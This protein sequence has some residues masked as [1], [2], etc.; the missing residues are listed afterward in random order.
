MG[1]DVRAKLLI[2]GNS[3]VCIAQSSDY[4]TRGSIVERDEAGN[5]AVSVAQSGFYRDINLGNGAVHI[6][7]YSSNFLLQW[8]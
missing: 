1:I 3:L 7:W 2:L 8:R 4:P 5:M 6:L